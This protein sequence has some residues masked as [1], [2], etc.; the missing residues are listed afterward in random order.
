MA[1]PKKKPAAAS[2]ALKRVQAAVAKHAHAKEPKD[3]QAA[4]RAIK[5]SD[6]RLGPLGYLFLATQRR[7]YHYL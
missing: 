4:A 2:D 7:R 5:G 1:G 3:I 6:P